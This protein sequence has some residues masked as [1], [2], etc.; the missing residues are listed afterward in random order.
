V[1]RRYV[2]YGLTSQDCTTAHPGVT[3]DPCGEAKN[4]LLLGNEE[5][6]ILAAGLKG[7]IGINDYSYFFKSRAM[8]G[9]R[10]RIL[11][12]VIHSKCSWKLQRNKAKIKHSKQ[13]KLESIPGYGLKSVKMLDTKKKNFLGVRDTSSTRCLLE[14]NKVTDYRINS[15]HSLEI[16]DSKEGAIMKGVF[17]LIP[18][19]K[20]IRLT[21]KKR[22]TFEAFESLR[23]YGRVN[24]HGPTT[25]LP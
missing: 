15:V 22:N 8:T 20:G 4:K 9:L 13:Q 11:H 18:R 5:K 19:V 16:I 10:I 25:E 3:R 21:C 24:N 17:T 12:H 7:C 1:D 6:Y 2:I 23:K 14:K